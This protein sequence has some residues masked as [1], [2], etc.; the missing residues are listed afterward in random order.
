MP[1]LFHWNA[2]EVPPF[3]GVAEKV[4]GVP[5][6]TGFTDAEIVIPATML[7]STVT[8]RLVGIRA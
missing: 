2:G 6:Q 3:I 5:E 7:E 8:S 4:T 1:F